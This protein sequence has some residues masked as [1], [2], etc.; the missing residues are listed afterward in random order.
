MGWYVTCK[1]CGQQEK[2]KHPDCGCLY[3]NYILLL[4]KL[5][6]SQVYDGHFGRGNRRRFGTYFRLASSDC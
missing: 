5:Q 2:Y 1:N 3:N 6:E 4:G